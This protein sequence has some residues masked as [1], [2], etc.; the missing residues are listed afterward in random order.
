MPRPADRAKAPR[1]RSRPSGVVE[2]EVAGLDGPLGPA[3]AP[4]TQVA[5]QPVGPNPDVC[6]VS[7]TNPSGSRIRA[8]PAS[9]RGRS[10][11]IRHARGPGRVRRSAGRGRRPAYRRP[12]RTS[13]SVKA[14]ASSTIQRIGP[15]GEPGQLG[16]PAGPGD[17]RARGVH[18]GDRP[19]RGG[20]R[21]RGQAR[22]REQVQDRR[23]GARP[24]G[25]PRDRVAQPGQHRRV[26]RE[27]PDLA[28]VGRS[29]LEAQAVDLDRPWRS[30]LGGAAPAPSRS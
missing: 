10:S 15:L 5:G 8:Q 20:H 7:R 25:P 13:R 18:V 1:P 24:H 30:G 19:T 27:E 23:R 12:R 26:L 6:A 14:R 21:E 29:Q 2:A 22:V 16:V 17:R 28:R 3:R 9:R 11:S 4:S